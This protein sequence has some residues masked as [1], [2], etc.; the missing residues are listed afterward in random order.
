[1]ARWAGFIATMEIIVLQVMV[2][3]LHIVSK[4]SKVSQLRDI[5]NIITFMEDNL[6]K[7]P[8]PFRR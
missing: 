4:E 2:T 8:Q 3:L 7:L 5:K 1:M 6:G